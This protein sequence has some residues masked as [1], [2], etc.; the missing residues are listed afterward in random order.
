MLTCFG[1]A[2]SETRVTRSKFSVQ[3]AAP[4]ANANATTP[5]AM[6]PDNE[7]PRARGDTLSAFPAT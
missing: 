7:K 1:E 6:L 2:A 5:N 3:T 4:D